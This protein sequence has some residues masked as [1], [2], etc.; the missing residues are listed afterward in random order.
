MNVN[1][2]SHNCASLQFALVIRNGDKL[3][4]H[5]EELVAGDIIEVKFGD[6]VP[7]DM[8][9]ISAHGFKVCY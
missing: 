3:N 6:R 7:A 4:L 9:V 2:Y 1:H 8:R 5:A